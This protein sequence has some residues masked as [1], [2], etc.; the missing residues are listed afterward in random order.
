MPTSSS[1]AS[2]SVSSLIYSIHR[3]ALVLLIVYFFVLVLTDAELEEKV[4]NMPLLIAR[5]TPQDF[6]AY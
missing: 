4:E 6:I 2:L 3:V 1:K 5:V